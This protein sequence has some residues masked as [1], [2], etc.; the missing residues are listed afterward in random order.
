M[1]TLLLCYL[2]GHGE[3]DTMTFAVL[4]ADTKLTYRFPLEKELRTIGKI[5]G[6]YVIGIFDCCRTNVDPALRGGHDA[7]D[8]EGPYKNFYF[9]FG[10]G[11]KDGVSL[12]STM[13][14]EWFEKFKLYCT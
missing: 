9:S 2:S 7:P 6:A 12:A 1:D 5:P 8:D 11:P 14:I 3:M 10:C 13:A 4:N